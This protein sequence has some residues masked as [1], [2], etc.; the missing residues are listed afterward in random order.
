MNKN[1]KKILTIS[2]SLSLCFGVF[3][4]AGTSVKAA[5]KRPRNS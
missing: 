4:N 5:T 1:L 2:L 3:F